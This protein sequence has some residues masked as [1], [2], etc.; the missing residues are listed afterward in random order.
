MK[1]IVTFLAALV[2]LVPA[3]SMAIQHASTPV[4]PDT[5][6]SLISEGTLIRIR[7]LKEVSSQYSKRGDPVSWVV[8]DN[9]LVGKRVVIPAGTLGIGHLTTVSPAHG[10]NTPGFLRIAFDPI[11]LTDG[12]R[13]DIAVTK[14]STIADEN[15]KNGYGPGADEAANIVIPYFFLVELVRKGQDMT[16]HQNAV[17]HVAVLEDCFVTSTAVALSATPAP[18]P[19]ATV[20]PEAGRSGP[21][22]VN[23]TPAAAA[24]A[25]PAPA[26]PASAPS[27]TP[28]P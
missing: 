21:A 9:V 3:A 22:A 23:G 8:S 26:A 20:A 18:S 19:V 17:F 10:G 7:V 12:S 1:I 27:P 14:A 28:T 25:A 4:N 5:R 11:L 13:V 16:I 6:D 24:T 2:T 15:E